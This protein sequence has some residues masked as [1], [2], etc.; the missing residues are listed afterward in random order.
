MIAAA[1]SMM[2]KWLSKS[3]SSGIERTD[4]EMQAVCVHSLD[5]FAAAHPYD[6][7]F[8]HELNL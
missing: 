7:C 3:S 8:P 1:S 5:Y 2:R 6:R 4:G